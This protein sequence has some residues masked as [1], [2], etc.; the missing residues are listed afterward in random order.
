MAVKA[1]KLGPGIL[2][3]KLDEGGEKK[4]EGQV[5]SIT[6]EPDYQTEDPIPVLSGDTYQAPGALTSKITGEMLQDYL[7]DSLLKYCYDNRGKTG[8][9]E[10][11]P[12][13]EGALKIAGNLM[14]TPV[15]IGGDLNKTNTISF[16]FPV[17]GDP[18]ITFDY[19]AAAHV[20]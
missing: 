17:V 18:E 12:S 1:S 6:W 5:T 15:G 10:F 13:K 8:S 11:V 7:A 2:T 14:V 16:E 4:F 3:I 20:I 9:F 19:D